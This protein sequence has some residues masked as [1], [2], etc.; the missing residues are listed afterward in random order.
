MAPAPE[1]RSSSDLKPT[2]RPISRKGWI[3]LGAVLAIVVVAYA[4]VA[5]YYNAEGGIAKQGGVGESPGAGI[6]VTIEPLSVDSFKNDATVHY[7]FDWEG[8][9]IVD[10]NGRLLANTRI[11]I[12]SLNGIEEVKFLA[13]EPLGQYVGQVGLEGEDALYPLDTH[14]G[15]I[16]V[17]ADTYV[18]G[19][20]G[21]LSSVAAVP[22]G[23][24]GRGGVNGWDTAMDLPAGMGQVSLST[25]TFSRAFSTQAFA[26]LILVLVVVLGVMALIVG[27][28]VQTNRRRA[29]ATLMSWAAALLFALP[30]LR[31]YMPNSP[32]VGAAIDVYVYLWAIVMAVLGLLFIVASWVR[33]RGAELTAEGADAD[34][35]APAG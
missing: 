20:D 34:G 32:P 14:V 3:V 16:A 1:R 7:A 11:T 6:V 21:S 15:N 19:S 13:G 22:L 2:P 30:L 17:S 4:L 12:G 9:G 26:L 10:E 31:N 35:D 25:V 5:V 27:L 28:L 24:D 23:V 33:Q 29:E 18:R 8:D